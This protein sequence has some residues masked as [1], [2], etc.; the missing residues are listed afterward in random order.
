MMKKLSVLLFAIFMYIGAHAQDVDVRMETRLSFCNTGF[1][2]ERL[3]LAVSG[4]FNEKW[5]FNFFQNLNKPI[6]PGDVLNATDKMFIRYA[7]DPAWTFQFGKMPLAI[8]SWEYDA[9]PIDVYYYT[10]YIDNYM[11]PF[12]IAISGQYNFRNGKDTVQFQFAR[13]PLAEV[14]DYRMFSYNLMWNGIH[15]PL[16]FLYSANVEQFNGGYRCLACLGTKLTLDRFSAYVDLSG[17]RF[18]NFGSGMIHSATACTRLDWQIIPKLSVF[19]KFTADRDRDIYEGVKFGGGFEFFPVK[20]S[21]DVRIHIQIHRENSNAAHATL[22]SAG[23][24][25]NFHIYRKNAEEKK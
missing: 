19:A 8:G 5:S 21:R 10:Y 13:S 15:G 22:A 24:K 11:S 20:G 25:W 3:S 14:G 6:E 4:S 12:Q 7:P 23:A 16:H 1:K 9:F 2:A 17:A 18:S